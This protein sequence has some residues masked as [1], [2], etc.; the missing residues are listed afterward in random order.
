MNESIC[1]WQERKVPWQCVNDTVLVLK[2]RG[3]AAL[4]SRDK[5]SAPLCPPALGG[6][7]IEGT[8]LRVASPGT[9]LLWEMEPA[10]GCQGA[11]MLC[12]EQGHDADCP[13]PQSHLPHLHVALQ[14]PHNHPIITPQIPHPLPALCPSPACPRT[15]VGA[16]V[17]GCAQPWPRT[18]HLISGETHHPA[19]LPDSQLH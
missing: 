9:P 18:V 7:G 2:P 3:R 16:A 14:I 8:E 12:W 11:C 10:V 13:L 15:A 6:E 19:P 17:L 5:S 4:P 1:C